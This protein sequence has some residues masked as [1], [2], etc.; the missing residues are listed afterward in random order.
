VCLLIYSVVVGL[1]LPCGV[2][3]LKLC[4]L[5]MMP[6]GCGCSD[7]AVMFLLLQMKL[8]IDRVV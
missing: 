6:S 8:V 7:V 5:W 4:T 1:Q 3:L 2:P